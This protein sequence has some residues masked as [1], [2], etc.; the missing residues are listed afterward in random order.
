MQ[1]LS[2]YHISAICIDEEVVDVLPTETIT[3]KKARRPKI[4][5]ISLFS[6]FNQVQKDHDF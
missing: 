2:I 1:I 5:I 6:G 4:L 3:F